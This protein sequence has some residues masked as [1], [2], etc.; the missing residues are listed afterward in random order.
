MRVAIRREPKKKNARPYVKVLTVPEDI[1]VQLS[2]ARNFAERSQFHCRLPANV[3][4]L[5]TCHFRTNPLV[6]PKAWRTSGEQ[7]QTCARGVRVW[8]HAS[9]NNEF[10]ADFKISA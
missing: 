4:E 3:V 6:A 5:D 8:M 9:Q 7:M 1:H 2:Q 10:H